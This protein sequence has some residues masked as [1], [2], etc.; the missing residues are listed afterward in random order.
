V[1]LNQRLVVKIMEKWGYDLD[2]AENGQI[3]VEKLKEKDYDL[4]LMDIQMPVMDGYGAAALIRSMPEIKKQS[5]P[6]IALTAHASQAEAEKCV[7][8]GMNAYVTKPFN[9]Q[10]LL[11]IINQLT[12]NS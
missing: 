5:T 1:I 6:I 11:Q 9:Q 2:V 10:S 8:L 12:N 4:I 3:A 7:N